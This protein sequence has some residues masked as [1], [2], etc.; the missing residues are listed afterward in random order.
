[1]SQ[2]KFEVPETAAGQTAAAFVR[3]S[4]G[5]LTWSEVRRHIQARRVIVNGVI[6]I[7]EARRLRAGDVVEFL[8]ESAKP[9]PKLR[10]VS[11]V[12]EDQSLVVIEKPAGMIC[13]RRPEERKWSR[14][15]K[16]QTTTVQEALQASGVEALP[17]HRLD[18]DTSGLMVY[19]KTPAAQAGLV[20]L[21]AKHQIERRYLAV[22]LGR[23]E[24]STVKT[25]IVRDRG[26]GLRGSVAAPHPD[27]E[28]AISHIAVREHLGDDYTIL[29]CRLETGRTHQIR[30][31]LAEMKHP[32]CG[33]KLYLKPMT[34]PSGA[35]RQALHCCRLGFVHPGTGK[36]IEFESD[37]P[38]DLKWWMDALRGK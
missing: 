16:D 2:Q 5:Q 24:A 20:R 30:I 10:D 21:F 33:E 8:K 26:D 29:E 31:H 19:A 38:A 27:A 3:G 28:E 9:A 37:W 17:V 11:V 18:R 32:I 36:P 14:Q 13:E 7:D 35:P 6:C 25:W 15:L 12:Y 23:V 22:A 34:D 1:M 4:V